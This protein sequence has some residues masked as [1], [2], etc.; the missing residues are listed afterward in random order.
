MPAYRTTGTPAKQATGMATHD[1]PS[2]IVKREAQ[3]VII[4]VVMEKIRV[5]RPVIIFM[6]KDV[7]KSSSA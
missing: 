6:G 2:R 3:N 5:K 1:F 4:M 7:R